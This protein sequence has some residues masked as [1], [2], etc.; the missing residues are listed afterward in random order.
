MLDAITL[1]GDDGPD[2]W[3]I[4]RSPTDS[5]NVQV[6]NH[7]SPTGDPVYEGARRTLDSLVLNGG[8]GNDRITIDFSLGVPIR[9]GIFTFDA[10]TGTD[11]SITFIGHSAFSATYS[12]TSFGSGTASIYR[13]SM[14][15]SGADSVSFQDLRSFS[16]FT[17]DPADRLTIDSPQSGQTRIRGTDTNNPAIAPATVWGTN[18]ITLDTSAEN[19]SGHDEIVLENTGLSSAGTL[20]ATTGTAAT[21]QNNMLAVNGGTTNFHAGWGTSGGRL[22]VSVNNS[23]VLNF[24]A[25]QYISS[26]TLNDSSRVNLPAGRFQ[27]AIVDT[28]SIASTN[29]TLDVGDNDLIIHNGSVS[30]VTSL[31]QRGRGTGNWQGTGITSS[32][33]AAAPSQTSA[34]GVIN[35]RTSPLDGQTVVGTDVLVKFVYGGDINF[36]NVINFDDYF[37][38]NNGFLNHLTGWFNGDFTYDGSI[39][40]S[41]YFVINTAFNYMGAHPA[42]PFTVT[43]DASIGEGADYEL[44]LRA[45]TV[46]QEGYWN[47]WDD[48]ENPVWVP[49]VY[50][51]AISHWTVY[52]GDGEYDS[53]SADVSG[54][55]LATHAYA[56]DSATART[57]VSFRQ[58]CLT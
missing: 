41:D 24:A 20:I 54:T 2:A 30:A 34:V 11:D 5:A 22:D 10:G 12:P 29:A 15:F 48:P 57:I 17:A 38:I 51:D 44:T 23:A 55:T 49:P 25:T 9:D 52:W 3:Y 40:G 56:D 31:I 26:L 58:A 27:I 35:N 43:G 14:S 39:N 32:V 13:K 36:N 45:G 8:A 1:Y 6:F 53:V 4:R 47:D 18:K 28:L 46:F 37:Q 7:S 21:G 50:Y 33:A 19:G 16:L 42:P